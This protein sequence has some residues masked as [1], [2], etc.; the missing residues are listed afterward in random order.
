MLRLLA[1]RH[2]CYFILFFSL[3]FF[4]GCF[5]EESVH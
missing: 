2:F 3:G 1:V 5:L 4:F